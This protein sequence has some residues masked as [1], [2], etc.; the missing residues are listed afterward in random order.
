[1]RLAN[2]RFRP[3]RLPR[4]EDFGI[5]F[6]RGADVGIA[7]CKMGDDLPRGEFLVDG[8]LGATTQKGILR[9]VLAPGRYRINPYAYSVEVIGEQVMKSGTQEKHA[10]WVNIPTGLVGV[11]THLAPNKALGTLPGIQNKVL[12]PGIYPVN[13]KEAIGL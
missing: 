4:A 7:A 5:Y 11:I 3:S 8:G 10:G 9:N 6:L 13:P 2:V 1:M 12:Q